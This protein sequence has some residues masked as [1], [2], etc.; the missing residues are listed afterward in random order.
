MCVCTCVLCVVCVCVHVFMVRVFMV[1]LL[2]CV[3]V[4]MQCTHPSIQCFLC[5]ILGLLCFLLTCV[6]A[7]SGLFCSYT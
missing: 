7:S 3:K 5:H 1:H 2:V 4:G 6:V